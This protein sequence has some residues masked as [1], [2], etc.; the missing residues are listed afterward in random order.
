MK[1]NVFEK[2]DCKL[3]AS[4]LVELLKIKFGEEVKLAELSSQSPD[5][6]APK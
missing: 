6:H 3:H 4:E 1:E 2:S 5:E